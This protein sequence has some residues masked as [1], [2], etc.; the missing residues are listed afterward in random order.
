MQLIWGVPIAGIVKGAVDLQL[1]DF[2]SKSPGASADQV[3]AGLHLDRRGAHILLE[4]TVA[5]QLTTRSGEGY[6]TTP[7]TE[8]FLV[9]T[10]PS[11]Q[12]DL[13]QLMGAPAMW[14]CYAHLAEATRAGGST[15]ADRADAAD[16]SLWEEFAEVTVRVATLG[17]Q[18]LATLLASR[19][20][21]DRE[22]RVLDVACGTGMYGLGVA[23]RFRSSSLVCVDG[24]RVLQ[25]TRR[26]AERLSL[27]DRTHFIAADMFSGDLGGSYDVVI[28]S[29][30]FHHFDDEQ[31]GLLLQRLAKATRPGGLIVI[32]D[33][34]IKDGAAAVATPEPVLFA[35]TMLVSTRGGDTYTSGRFRDLLQ[36]NGFEAPEE[37]QVPRMPTTF[38][39]AK[40]SAG[41]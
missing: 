24:E 2:L 10:S 30:V 9:R 13:I 6:Q 20:A 16:Y 40:R 36:R 33:W 12:G 19:L 34:V 27:L 29:H 22:L 35:T 28:A 37:V 5:L 1:F 39:L 38:I 14:N 23:Q 8:Q 25:R 15:V 18:A 7:E 3:A 26:N 41:G 11:Y 32:H 4:A 31:S 17:G 21:S